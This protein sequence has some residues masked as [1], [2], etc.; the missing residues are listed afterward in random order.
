MFFSPKNA[1][2][3]FQRKVKE[4]WNIPKKH[5]YLSIN[6]IQESRPILT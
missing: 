4:L 2:A 6:G 5:Y 3:D 1:L